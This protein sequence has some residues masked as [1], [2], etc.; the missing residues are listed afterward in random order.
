MTSLPE[1]E[2]VVDDSVD[3]RPESDLELAPTSMRR[4]AA[5]ARRVRGFSAV[6]VA[7]M[8]SAEAA[9]AIPGASLPPMPLGVVLAGLLL[10]INFVDP[11]R[12][13][14]VT[15]R[16]ARQRRMIETELDA[17]IVFSAIWLVGLNPA[18]SLWVL[19]LFPMPQAVLRFDGRQM[20]G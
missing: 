20:A 2:D 3:T 12:D 5:M 6:V 19:L 13:P 18:S 10:F 8:M 14:L 4:D 11:T 15:A 16:V 17:S 9:D 1:L 7:L